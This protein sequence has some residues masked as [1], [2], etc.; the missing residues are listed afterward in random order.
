[1]FVTQLEVK[2]MAE[3][4]ISEVGRKVGVQSSAIRYYEQIGL[5]PPARRVSGQRRY[6]STMLYRLAVI[7]RARQLGFT[8]DEIR[9]LFF[10]VRS[11]TRASERWQ[12]LSRRKMAELDDLMDG[13]ES[14]R[15]LL[16]RMLKN[17]RCETL[18]QC[19]KEIFRSGSIDLAGSVTANY[20]R[21]Q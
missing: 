2:S 14:V 13:I 7:Q 18:E 4:T 5:L 16:R 8:L 3:F 20:R 21:R 15:R 12:Q 11:A 10:D 17:C 19:G 6:D 1:M 9:Q